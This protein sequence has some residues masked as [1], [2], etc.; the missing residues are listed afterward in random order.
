MNTRHESFV[1]QA[2]AAMNRLLRTACTLRLL[3]V[4]LLWA[5]PGVV[6]A[7]SYTNNYGIWNYTTT[8]DTI[9][10]TGYSGPGGDVTIP[11]TINGAGVTTIGDSAFYD[12]TTLTSVTI[13]TNVTSIGDSAFEFCT[14]LTAILV[15]TNNPAYS[16]L[17]GVLFDKNQTTLVE[18]PAGMVGSYTIPNTV[19]TIWVRAF[20]G[21]S[22]LTSVTIGNS[23]TSIGSLGFYDCTR[24]TSVYF[25]GN[26]PSYYFACPFCGAFGG[27]LNPT[28]YYLPGTTGWGPTF[29]ALP[30]VL[31]NA[32]V[33]P[34]SYGVRTNQFGFNITGSSNLVIV[35]EATTNLAN[36][37][38]YPLQTNTLNGS[39]LYFTDPQWTNYSSRF[40][41]V[42]WP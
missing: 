21:C 3:S 35:I 28:G 41:R 37:N 6:E 9:T 5:L 31:W 38:W 10:I 18:C 2:G 22:G 4:L 7:Q 30:T 17:D 23:V 1:R 15:D 13:G 12:N 33:E 40:Y 32:Q 39:P 19:T 24:L 11:S 42:T 27:D 34:G 8:N 26:A 14:G 36:P 20:F 16:S 25:L 29:A